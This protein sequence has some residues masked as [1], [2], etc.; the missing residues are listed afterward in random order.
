MKSRSLLITL[1]II[2]AFICTPSLVF[3][4]PGLPYCAPTT[5]APLDGGLT[6]LI[7]AGIGYGVKKVYDKRKKDKAADD[8]II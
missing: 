1:I 3:A 7:A 5:Q 2:C 8:S 6:L 4:G